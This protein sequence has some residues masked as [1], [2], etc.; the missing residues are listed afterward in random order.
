MRQIPPFVAAR[1]KSHRYLQ[2]L[3]TTSSYRESQVF[4]VLY[5]PSL[6]PSHV[7]LQRFRYSN[8]I[9]AGIAPWG[10]SWRDRTHM[11]GFMESMYYSHSGLAF[12]YSAAV[13]CKSA[14]ETYVSGRI[15]LKPGYTRLVLE[16]TK[17]NNF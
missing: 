8:H 10:G 16:W 12:A 1:R 17:W 15:N 4:R 11:S 5:H 2:P 3:R 7:L 13:R 9:G 6:E 14:G